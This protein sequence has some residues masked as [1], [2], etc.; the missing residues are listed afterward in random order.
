MQE[1]PAALWRHAGPPR[2]VLW[3]DLRLLADAES[4]DRRAIALGALLLEV[5]EQ[6]APLADELEQTAAAVMVLL[7]RLEMLGQ[8]G[9]PT[10]EQR[11]LDLGR[12]GV[13]L[14]LPIVV[15]DGLLLLAGLG[16]DLFLQSDLY[17]LWDFS[18]SVGS[19]NTIRGWTTATPPEP[20]R[21]TT[22]PMARK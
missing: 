2:E 21:S 16:Q 1:G 5:V 9:D 14:V 13:L 15:D 3:T 18:T 12:S 19:L 7:V 22:E 4:L 17:I 6:A 8:L 20:I 10:G 11:D